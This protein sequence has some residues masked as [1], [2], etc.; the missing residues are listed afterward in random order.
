MDYF[1]W[2]LIFILILQL[3]PGQYKI[4]EKFLHG[5]NPPKYSFPKTRVSVKVQLSPGP[6]QYDVPGSLG[7]QPLSTKERARD[8][9]FPQAARPS[10]IAPGRICSPQTSVLS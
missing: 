6:G 7:K 10:L 4:A 5:T 3:G 1:L 9:P 8:A 2:L